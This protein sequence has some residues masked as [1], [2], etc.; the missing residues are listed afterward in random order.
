MISWIS[1]DSNLT[2]ADQKNLF[3][4][5]VLLHSC[6]L[7]V[8]VITKQTAT[9]GRGFIL[10]LAHSGYRDM[11]PRPQ[12]NKWCFSE[13]VFR[14]DSNSTL[15]AKMSYFDQK[16]CIYYPYLILNLFWNITKPLTKV[17]VKM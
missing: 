11:L 6:R 12:K 10:S 8:C 13:S 9:S 3:K 2:A 14:A 17:G 5:L 4:K 1:H 7:S 16:K 15:Q